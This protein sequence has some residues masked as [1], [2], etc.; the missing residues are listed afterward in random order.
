MCLNCRYRAVL[1]PITSF[2]CEMLPEKVQRSSQTKLSFQDLNMLPPEVVARISEV[3][4][5]DLWLYSPAHVGPD[6][7]TGVPDVCPCGLPLLVLGGWAQWLTAKVE[8]FGSKIK[9]ESKEAAEVRTFSYPVDLTAAVFPPQHCS[10]ACI[11]QW[12]IPSDSRAAP[13]TRVSH[14]KSTGLGCITLYSCRAETL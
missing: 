9:P 7:W 13:I 3:C 8:F 6:S 5:R 1:F 4:G 11:L 14:L 10:C 2:V 12:W